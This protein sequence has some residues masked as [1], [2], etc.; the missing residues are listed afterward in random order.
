MLGEPRAVHMISVK[1][2]SVYTPYQSIIS[3][4]SLAII[5]RLLRRARKMRTHKFA[6]CLAGLAFVASC[7]VQT[8]ATQASEPA[9]QG[10]AA[11]VQMR[12]EEAER[13]WRALFFD[14]LALEI[15]PPGLSCDHV[16]KSKP[17]EIAGRGYVLL[18]RTGP[19]PAKLIRVW[20]PPGTASSP[21]I[22]SVHAHM[23]AREAGATWA[24]VEDMHTF[25]WC[26]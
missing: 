23:R 14:E 26:R 22:A 9:F 5:E 17:N 10:H 4:P 7:D 20:L 3:H 11:E 8:A 18:V 25:L 16:A 21:E 19:E 2:A 13:R 6:A 1:S 12:S 15:G 24:T